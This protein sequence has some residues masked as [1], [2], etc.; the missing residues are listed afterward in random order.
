MKSRL[1][2]LSNLWGIQRSEWI[3]YYVDVLSSDYDIKY[4]DSCELAEIETG[5]QTCSLQM[6]RSSFPELTEKASLP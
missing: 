3:K 6:K 5:V 1:I 4:Y 2:L